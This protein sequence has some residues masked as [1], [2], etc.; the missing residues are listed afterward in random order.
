MDL[1]QRFERLQRER[2]EPAW[3]AD[4]PGSAKDHVV[5]ALPSYSLDRSV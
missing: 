1:A 2:L 5:V 3:R 4:L